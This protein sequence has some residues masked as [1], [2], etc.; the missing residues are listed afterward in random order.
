MPRRTY[1]N[2]SVA[3]MEQVEQ[4][5]PSPYGTIVFHS[6]RRAT[7][8]CRKCNYTAV[9]DRDRCAYPA[10]HFNMRSR[11][12]AVLCSHFLQKHLKTIH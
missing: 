12:H 9:L 8:H 7:V 4:F 3:R 11:A 1:G 2:V 5:D 6:E 10:R